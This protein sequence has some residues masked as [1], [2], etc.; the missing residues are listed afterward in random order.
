MTTCAIARLVLGPD[1]NLQAPP[2]LSAD[3][4]PLLLTGI[5]DWGGV[6]PVT[7]D[8]INPERPWPDLGLMAGMCQ[9]SGYPLRERLTVYPEYALDPEWIDAGV[10]PYVEAQATADGYP[11]TDALDAV[12]A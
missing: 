2:N 1:M 6:S 3:Y 11:K 9:E 4:G 5:N 12:T 7:P 8:F 10:L